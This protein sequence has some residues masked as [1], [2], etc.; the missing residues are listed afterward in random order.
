MRR[1]LMIPINLHCPGFNKSTTLFYT[2]KSISETKVIYYDQENKLQN[3][4]KE[5]FI[6]SW[7][8]VC[9]LLVCRIHR[10]L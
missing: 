1:N 8:E 5:Q 6:K 3:E 2:L 4:A 7:T 9:L 10:K